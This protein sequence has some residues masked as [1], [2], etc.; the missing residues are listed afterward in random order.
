M[1]LQARGFSLI[2]LL[3][4]IS[5]IAILATIVIAGV[6]NSRAESRDVQRQAD[7]RNVQV[8]LEAYKVQYGRYPAG[9]NGA[10]QW[11]GQF[12]SD[13]ECSGGEREYIIGHD[14]IAVDDRPFAFAPAFIKHLPT[15]PLPVSGP[16]GY[17]YRTNAEGSVYKF[18]A[19][20]TVE[21]DETL[22]I[23]PGTTADP[24]ERISRFKE[25]YSHPFKACDRTY[26]VNF[27][28][29]GAMPIDQFT[30]TCDPTNPAPS[31]NR[32]TYGCDIGICDRRYQT[33][34]YA[35]SNDSIHNDCRAG[36]AIFQTSYAV[37]GGIAE[38]NTFFAA[39]SERYRVTSEQY[40]E[41]I[42]C[43]MP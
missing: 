35:S 28:F 23:T 24:L 31:S 10:N 36:S 15:D 7:L 38:G 21:A 40:T 25:V 6:G 16:Q 26:D 20:R 17:V 2:E 30:Q 42:L 27:V 39:G 1:S 34:F 32:N 33:T 29:G 5:I 9:C 13:Y 41:N 22:L 12:G 8:A 4:V 14:D 37:W 18:M 43:A 11:S 3:I 19:Y